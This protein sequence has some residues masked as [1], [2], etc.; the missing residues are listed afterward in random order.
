M[1]KKKIE[2]EP[3]YPQLRT[4]EFMD[5]EGPITVVKVWCDGRDYDPETETYKPQYGYS[6]TGGSWSYVGNDIRG[7][8]NELPNLDKASQTL[9]AMLYASQKSYSI[10]IKGAFTDGNFEMFP[11]HV[12]EW[13]VKFSQ[14]IAQTSIACELKVQSQ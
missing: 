10:H 3:L 2:S 13:A 8:A 9:F 6:I 1:P 14:D 12:N 4:F 5:F 11:V 7:A